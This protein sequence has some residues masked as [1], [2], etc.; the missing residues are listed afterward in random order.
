MVEELDCSLKET[1]TQLVFGAGSPNADI[2]F[3]GEAP[4]EKEDLSGI[5]FVGS[6]GRE[7][8][9][10]LT[11]I[12]LSREDIYISNIV[13]YRPP[14]NRNPTP[15]EIKNHSPYLVEQIQAI[16]PRLIVTLGNFSTKFVLAG[17]DLEK[18]KLMPGITQIHGKVKEVP[19][20]HVSCKVLPLF[21]PAAVLYRPQ[22]RPE[23]QADFLKI[24][25]FLGQQVLC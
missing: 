16:K 18:M 2:L 20:D 25:E 21:H 23:L 6:A 12:S 9:K 4:G 22:L 15:E 24:K 1:A 17:F 14:K 10:L 13:K 7:L 19:H 5:P 8:D 11:S 3:I